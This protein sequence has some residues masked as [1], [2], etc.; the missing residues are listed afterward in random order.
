MSKIFISHSSKDKD[1]V[2]AFIEDI[3]NISLSIKT[4]DIFCTSTDGT[5]IKSGEDWRNT[6]YDNL[7]EAK[8]IFLIITPNYK[9]S[10]ICQNEMGAAWVSKGKT[11]P[12]IIEP[13]EYESVGVL[14]EVNQIEKLTN[15]KS[16]DKLRDS[17]QELLNIPLK[18]I[19]SDLWTTKKAEFL[20]KIKYFLSENPFIEPLDRI[21]FINTNSK[22]K[23]LSKTIDTLVNKNLHYEK[24][25]EELK[26][27]KDKKE[28][29]QLD[30]TLGLTTEFEEFEKICSEIAKLLKKFTPII[31]AYIFKDFSQKEISIEISPADSSDI[32]EAIACDILD[33]NL[34]VIWD[35]PKMQML[36]NL[37]NDLNN[38]LE[39]ETKTECFLSNF[40]EEYPD[41]ILNMKNIDFWREIF[42]TTIYLD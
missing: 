41:C 25:I 36:Y 38:F 23:D 5:K 20:A 19:R 33:E 21:A 22:N 27:L 17:V 15:E 4:S 18:D 1:L 32:S 9:E 3:L 14:Q 35:T 39:S 6:I 24:H 13:I 34:N 11:M 2:K 30:K 8:I 10:E 16:L 42:R 28:I 7:T 29:L 31:R 26:K 12:L 40:R 37:L